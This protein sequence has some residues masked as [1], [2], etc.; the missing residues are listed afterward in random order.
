V[1][2]ALAGTTEYMLSNISY[3]N[4]GFA[5]AATPSFWETTGGWLLLSILIVIGAV[6]LIFVASLVHKMT[7]TRIIKRWEE[8]GYDISYFKELWDKKYAEAVFGSKIKK[9]V[10]EELKRT[11]D[12][13]KVME[14]KL[15]RINPDR[16]ILVDEADSIKAKLKSPTTVTQ[17]EGDLV[18]LE[19]KLNKH[20][21]H[22]QQFNQIKEKA[23]H[24]IREADVAVSQLKTLGIA[25]GKA[26]GLLKK[27]HESYGINELEK[28]TDEAQA[29][30][31]LAQK[32]K[33]EGKPKIALGFETNSFE[34]NEWK[35]SDLVL[36]NEG[37]ASAKLVELRFSSEVVVK[38]LPWL[39]EL[40]PDSTKTLQVSLKPKDIGKLPLDVEI[41]YRDYQNKEY[42]NTY[43]F[44]LQVGKDVE[45]AA[46]A[47][48][49]LLQASVQSLKKYESFESIG[50]GGYADI[51]KAKRKK[52]GTSVALKLPRMSQL[53]P[54]KANSFL[55]EAKIWKKL[56]HPNIVTVYEYGIR[57]YPWIAM[58]YMSGGS[59][60]GEIGKLDLKESIDILLSICDALYY[61][62]HLGVVHR[63]I[64][65]DN[66][67]FSSNGTPKI[68]DW[69][70]G[71]LMLDISSETGVSGTPAYS[72]PEQIDPQKYGD[73]G[74]WT[75]IYELAA[76]AYEMFTGQIP[77]S[78]KSPLE[79][80]LDILNVDLAEPSS[81]KPEI[82]GQ[83]DRLLMRALS[84]KKD[85]RF[86]D[87][88]VMMEELGK[89]KKTMK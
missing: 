74:W 77:F 67:L 88:S 14:D 25:G 33:R 15:A 70:L 50:F 80:A 27:A 11:I 28:A 48:L 41:S 61:A 18:L 4:D 42:S 43:R 12:R 49:T 79:L 44:W 75:D 13:L 39:A 60:R 85:E 22:Q 30:L 78:G 6:F 63:D 8:E 23:D 19:Y 59:L 24:F 37:G 73:T 68:G 65:P 84:R 82:P 58:E 69:G 21:K 2:I 52:D 34:P 36:R 17:V 26:E 54:A 57:P 47:E 87:V 31:N 66:L 55:E 86:K 45:E 89:I 83:L 7:I 29:T 1:Q 32:I 40:G 35:R 10:Y 76:M 51:Y 9:Q 5:A 81:I 38:D 53:A 3:T 62:H 20:L 71:K 72:A 64:K 16:G 56:V 46:A